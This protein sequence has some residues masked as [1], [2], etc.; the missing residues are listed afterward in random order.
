M[1]RSTTAPFALQL[2]YRTGAF[3]RPD[4][5]SAEILPEHITIHTWNDCT[6]VELTHHLE[7][8]DGNLLPNPAV[9]TR[10]AF[11]LFFQDTRGAVTT[12]RYAIKD[13]GSVVIGDG[14]P[15]LDPDNPDA[16]ITLEDTSPYKTLNDARF[17]VG[18]YISCAILPPLPDGS[19]A[20]ASSARGGRGTGAGESPFAVGR[21][22]TAPSRDRENGFMRRNQGPPNNTRP[23]Y[24]GWGRGGRSRGRVPM[25]EWRR[26]EELPEIPPERRP[27]DRDRLDRF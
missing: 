5:F 15:G 10:L 12:G 21:P 26:G 18:D 20:P 25:G 1:D 7:T 16:N 14:G 19:V 24:E 8:T 11:R 3:H 22:P 4:E 13:M 27:Y 9:G 17:V 2:F 6:L 23:G